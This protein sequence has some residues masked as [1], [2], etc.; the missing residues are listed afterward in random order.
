MVGNKRGGW[1][2]PVEIGKCKRLNIVDVHSNQLIGQIPEAWSGLRYLIH[3]NLRGNKLHG[4]LPQLGQHSPLRKVYFSEN[5][6]SGTIPASYAN[7][8]SI[9][10]FELSSNKL[11]N[12]LPKSLWEAW[13]HAAEIRIS[14][15]N[16]TGTLPR[17]KSLS[18]LEV[19]DASQNS[20]SGIM[21]GMPDSESSDTSHLGLSI[22]LDDNAFREFPVSFRVMPSVINLQLARNQIKSLPPWGLGSLMDDDLM[23]DWYHKGFLEA[24]QLLTPFCNM[25]TNYLSSVIWPRLLNV[26]L[27]G[28]KFD[29]QVSTSSFIGFFAQAPGLVSMACN[30]CNLQGGATRRADFVLLPN[31][32]IRTAFRNDVSLSFQY[33]PQIPCDILEVTTTSQLMCSKCLPYSYPPAGQKPISKQEGCMCPDSFQQFDRGSCVCPHGSFVVQG[34]LGDAVAQTACIRCPAGEFTNVSGATMSYSCES[35]LRGSSTLFQGATKSDDC[36][37]MAGTY[38]GEL[39][40]GRKDCMQCT[41]GLLCD[42]N[43]LKEPKQ[44]KGYYIHNKMPDQVYRCGSDQECPAGAAGNCARGRQGIACGNCKE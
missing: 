25:D 15:N 28:N 44:D 38:N 29:S 11:S 23:D 4:P 30:D 22:N 3:L 5:D 43:D 6:L 17:I 1:S 32:K 26:D 36:I 8:S 24:G 19:L 2:I 9:E 10:Y 40:H 42:E 31:C 27:S 7:L 41:K 35:I 34:D 16:F 18:K 13:L 20:F 14:N 39:L 37:C 12:D 33:N 21:M